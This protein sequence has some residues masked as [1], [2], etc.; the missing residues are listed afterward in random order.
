MSTSEF[1]PYSCHDLR[2]PDLVLLVPEAV[3]VEAFEFDPVEPGV[4][5][6]A[7][8]TATPESRMTEAVTGRIAVACICCYGQKEKKVFFDELN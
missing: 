6:A 5:G 4:G 7:R 2:L 1:R 3:G 8:V